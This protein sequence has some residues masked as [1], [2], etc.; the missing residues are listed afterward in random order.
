M[1][2]WPSALAATILRQMACELQGRKQDYRASALD[3]QVYPKGVT[4]VLRQ[5]GGRETDRIE[6]TAR[7]YRII[8]HS[9]SR[10]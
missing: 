8:L 10:S 6:N 7:S 4:V 2:T 5:D 9:K 3:R 1:W